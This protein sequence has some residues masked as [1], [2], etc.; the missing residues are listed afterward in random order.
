MGSRQV[1]LDA[2]LRDSDNNP[3]ADKTIQF[4]YRASGDTT[5]TSAGTATTLSL[6]VVV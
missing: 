6:N 4:F 2:T 3:I 5:W 1:R